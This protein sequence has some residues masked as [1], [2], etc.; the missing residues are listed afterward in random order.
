VP[1]L[2]LAVPFGEIEIKTDTSVF[3]PV[4]LPVTWDAVLP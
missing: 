2:R 4:A 1:S 3:G